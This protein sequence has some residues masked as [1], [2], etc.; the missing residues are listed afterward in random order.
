MK[1]ALFSI[2]WA[3][4]FLL[5]AFFMVLGYEVVFGESI[6]TYD[7]VL[8]DIEHSVYDGDTLKD[9]RVLIHRYD[10]IRQEYGN[11]WPGLFITERGVEVETDIRIAGIDTPEKRVSTKN[12]DGSPRSVKSRERERR[13]AYASRQALMDMLRVSEGRFT[14]TNPQHGKYAGRTVADVSVLEVNVAA[15][16]IRLGHAK[17]YDGGT[18]PNWNWGD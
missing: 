11:P 10:F 1:S 4:A 18:K 9:M 12:A 13:A 14:I 3:I 17:K 15:E 8:S 2:L 16:L 5:A 6:P 7:C